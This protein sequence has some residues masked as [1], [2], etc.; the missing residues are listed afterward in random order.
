MS[1]KN[2]LSGA[3]E[4]RK[5]MVGIVAYRN[6]AKRAEFLLRVWLRVG[7]TSRLE[8]HTDILAYGRPQTTRPSRCAHFARSL[9]DQ[10]QTLHMTLLAVLLLKLTRLISRKRRIVVKPF[11][12]CDE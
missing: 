1:R 10:F 5:M 4:K 6:V 9:F 12:E 2:K 7:R 3:D 8:E 11:A